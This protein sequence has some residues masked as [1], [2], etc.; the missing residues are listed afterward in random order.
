MELPD[1]TTAFSVWYMAP[2]A[3]HVMT[4][5]PLHFFSIQIS[6]KPPLGQKMLN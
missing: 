3:L 1:M 4:E 6:M 5:F 2:T